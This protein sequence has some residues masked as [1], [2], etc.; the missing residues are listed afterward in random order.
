MS[1]GVDRTIIR[2]FARLALRE[3]IGL[4]DV[5]TDSCVDADLVAEAVIYCKDPSV[6]VCGLEICGEIF[7]TYDPSIAVFHH[8]HDGDFLKAQTGDSSTDNSKHQS[9]RSSAVMRA[10]CRVKGKAASLLKTER[11]VLNL[12]G[13]MCGIATHTRELVSSLG[14]SSCTLLDTRKTMPGLKAFDKYAARVGGARNHRFHLGDGVLIKENH[15]VACGGMARAIRRV[16]SAA[17]V[18]LKL[19]VEARTLKE[20]TLAL[21]GGADM[22]MLDNMSCAQMTEC[23]RL[24]AGKVPLEA[25]GNIHQENLAQVAG[26]GVDYIS[27]S[28]MFKAPP[29]DL[30][31]LLSLIDS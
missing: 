23:V 21:Q 11:V 24:V 14:S 8:S 2:E 13:R 6:V 12:L 18:S 31:F 9:G 25:S 10:L 19:E 7:R 16:R 5:T 3:D 28:A 29:A 26:C 20:V 17:P 27:T 4:G 22:I 1:F 15:V 30:S